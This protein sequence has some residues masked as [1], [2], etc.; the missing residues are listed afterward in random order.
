[1]QTRSIFSPY[2]QMCDAFR[3]GVSCACG[4]GGSVQVQR[5]LGIQVMQDGAAVGKWRVLSSRA[6]RCNVGPGA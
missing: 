1:L 5:A 2:I 6:P 3:H 4:L